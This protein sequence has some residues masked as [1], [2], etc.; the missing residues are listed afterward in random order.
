M[1]SWHGWSGSS[2]RSPWCSSGRRPM[3]DPVQLLLVGTSHRHAPIGVREQ[4]ATHAHGRG[5]IESV[6][7]EKA[8]IEAVGLSTCNRCEL[9]MVGADPEAMRVAALRRLAAYAHR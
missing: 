9:Y 2:T 8:V 7:A 1:P 6:M 5:L 4:L 3:A